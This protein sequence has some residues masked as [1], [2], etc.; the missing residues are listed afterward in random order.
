MKD[1]TALRN[2][3]RSQRTNDPD[4]NRRNI[5]DVATHEFAAKGFGGTRVDAFSG[6]PACWDTRVRGGP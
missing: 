5:I 3:S 1:A 4:G 6:F 2:R